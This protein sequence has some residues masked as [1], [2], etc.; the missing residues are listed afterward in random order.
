MGRS[1]IVRSGITSMLQ[2]ATPHANDDDM[3]G[4]IDQWVSKIVK[5]H[6]GKQAK[7]LRIP[8]PKEVKK[9]NV[10]EKSEENLSSS[11]S[12]VDESLYDIEDV[13]QKLRNAGMDDEFM[14]MLSKSDMIET[15]KTLGLFDETAEA[16]TGT[17]A[18]ASTEA[19]TEPE[20]PE[21]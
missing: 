19:E 3:E 14:N 18:E 10:V 20:T 11:I 5:Q 6:K 17:D 16:S 4:S 12:S 8:Q 7:W 21:E 2:I 15:A 1:F 9:E 13:K